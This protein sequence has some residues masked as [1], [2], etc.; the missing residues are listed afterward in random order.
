[1]EE[2]RTLKRPGQLLQSLALAGRKQV[3]EL[4]TAQLFVVKAGQA[5]GRGIDI[6]HPLIAR[7]NEE[8]GVV[9]LAKQTAHQGFFVPTFGNRHFCA[10]HPTAAVAATVP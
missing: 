8:G 4:Q 1:M 5:Q 9:G 3:A 10:S 7:M 2:M 6:H